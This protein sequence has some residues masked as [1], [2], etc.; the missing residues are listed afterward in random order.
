MA[1]NCNALRSIPLTPPHA[2]LSLASSPIA[3]R[4]PQRLYLQE[5]RG[6]RE[7]ASSVGRAGLRRGAGFGL[8]KTK[9]VRHMPDA[10]QWPPNS[11][12]GR[13]CF[14]PR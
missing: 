13:A 10:R 1:A 14:V 2:A 11:R 8:S 6:R 5:A 9:P 12:Q 3:G 4:E 7:G